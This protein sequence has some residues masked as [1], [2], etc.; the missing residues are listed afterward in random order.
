M[1]KMEYEYL[2]SLRK[3]P[4]WRL[5][6][7]DTAPLI[8]SF[9][10]SV[11]IQAN[12]R[13][14]KADELTARLDDYLYQLRQ[15]YGDEFFPRKPSDYLDAWASGEQAFLRKYYPEKSDEAEYDLTPARKR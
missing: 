11:F 7:A 4:A 5:L 10:H 2:L 14:V 8:I 6:T 3:H 1:R 9:F 15:V 12:R 13:A